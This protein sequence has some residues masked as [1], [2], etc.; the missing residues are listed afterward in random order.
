MSE[1]SERLNKYLANRGV[2]SRRAIDAMIHSGRI[3]VN[4]KP[5]TL[6]QRVTSQDDIKIDNQPINP[7]APQKITIALH[8]P[9]GVTTTKKDPFA[10]VTVMDLL[11]KEW[12]HLNP[13]GRLDRASRGLIL[14]TNDGDL[15]YAL[16]HPKHEHE[17]EYVV[18]VSPQ[19][20]IRTNQFDTDIQ[21]LKSEII[22]P[23]LQTKPP[24]I[25][26]SRFNLLT[27]RGTVTLVLEEGKKRQIRR[28]FSELGYYVNDLLR[29]RI[30]TITLGQL[31]A[32]EYRVIDPSE[33]K[34]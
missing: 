12:Q 28:L 31:K 24:R 14:L 15:A 8:K 16:E 17:K 2:G 7:S 25:L 29:T 32:G 3:N 20:S 9:Q 11:P 26:A 1:P 6:G 19:F 13:V 21:R 30:N 34:L 27:Q 33:L 18:E 5:A 23:N 10:K 4:G 22:N